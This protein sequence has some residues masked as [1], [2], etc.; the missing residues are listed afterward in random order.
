MTSISGIKGCP[1]L[2]KLNLAGNKIEAFD[3][4]PDLPAL[5]EINMTGCPIAK[6]EEVGKLITL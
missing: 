2:K 4:V 5:E 3:S 6:I 1:C